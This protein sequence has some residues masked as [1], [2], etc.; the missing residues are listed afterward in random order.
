MGSARVANFLPS[1]DGFRFPNSFQKAALFSV[2]GIP[3]GNAEN[4]MCGGMA[5]AARDFFEAGL[6]CP[7]DMETPPA[8]TPL[9]RYLVL[10]L[11]SS[12][13]LPAGPLRYLLW[14]ALPQRNRF[15]LHGVAW[16]TI[17]G[18][19]PAVKNDLDRG[20]LSPLGLV[21]TRGNP[22]EVGRNHQVLAHGYDLDEATSELTVHVYDPNHP[23]DD[24]VAIRLKVADPT[25]GPAIHYEPMEDP[26]YGFFRTSYRSADPRALRGLGLAA[27]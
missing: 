26:V 20:I 27:R 14:M 10:R 9:F 7:E 15:G 11:F 12:F 18:Q 13:N 21:R 23:G 3:I 22:L 25:S 6:R 1:E 8:G 5:F 2:L 16:R 19:W 24:G 4:G 17:R